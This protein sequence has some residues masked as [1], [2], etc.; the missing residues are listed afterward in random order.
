[1]IVQKQT[2]RSGGFKM[3][4]KQQETRNLSKSISIMTLPT[5]DE[6]FSQ[7]RIKP[8]DDLVKVNNHR[9]NHVRISK[10]LIQ[11][12]ERDYCKYPNSK[13]N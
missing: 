13:N 8:D 7:L 4:A 2:S 1:M 5:K 3:P 6:L 9:G 11:E 12:K 10:Q